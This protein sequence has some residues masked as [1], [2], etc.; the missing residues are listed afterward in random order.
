MSPARE[1]LTA[2]LGAEIDR[3][4]FDLAMVHRSFAFENGNPPTNAAV[5]L[6]SVSSSRMPCIGGIRTRAK[7]S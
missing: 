3:E 7:A 5:M 1:D 2:A 4:L 6:F